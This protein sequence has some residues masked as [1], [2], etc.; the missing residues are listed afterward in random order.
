MSIYGHQKDNSFVD[1]G[2]AVKT[3]DKR[4]KGDQKP[5]PSY[6]EKP[7]T[8]LN[9]P[10]DTVKR[11]RLPGNPFDGV[12]EH[13]A[14]KSVLGR[15]KYLPSMYAAF[16]QRDLSVRAMLAQSSKGQSS[17]VFLQV[18]D[19]LDQL[20]SDA[21]NAQCQ[22]RLHKAVQTYNHKSTNTTTEILRQ[23]PS[24]RLSS[25]VSPLRSRLPSAVTSPRHGKSKS[26]NAYVQPE[27][28]ESALEK[29]V[30]LEDCISPIASR[31]ENSL[32]S[33]DDDCLRLMQGNDF[34]LAEIHAQTERISML[35]RQICQTM[36]TSKQLLSQPVGR[37][38]PI[39]ELTSPIEL[40]HKIPADMPRQEQ[41]GQICEGLGDRWVG[42]S[43]E[44][45]S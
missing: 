28:P 14:L 30:C 44:T 24:P 9:S 36:A 26:A 3:T 12:R 38:T 15:L 32:S 10:A 39:P 2:R 45:F 13:L 21:E 29:F 35:N 27:S 1:R 6:F 34:M 31:I 22:T 33:R 17:A 25:P 5:N 11:A 19:F 4:E 42:E 37:R 18:L 23:T 43:C 41:R 40:P 7:L 16:K 20:M 8:R